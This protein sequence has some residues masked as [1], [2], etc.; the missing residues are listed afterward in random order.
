M[1]MSYLD[2]I[3]KEIDDVDKQLTEQFERRME[4]VSKVYKYKKENKIPILNSSREKQVIQKNTERLNNK[5]WEDYLKEFFIKLIDLSK[6]YQ[7]NE[8]NSDG[9]DCQMKDLK[10]YYMEPCPFCKKVIRY[11]GKNNIDIDLVDIR[12]NPEN[13]KELIEIGGKDQV[14]MLL[15]D[16]KPLYESSDIIKWL[17]ENM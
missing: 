11:M 14:P 5:E 1:I 6:S 2:D 9:R 7:Y 15:I 3:R 8:M 16:G 13:N 4:L 12:A 17:K 10:L